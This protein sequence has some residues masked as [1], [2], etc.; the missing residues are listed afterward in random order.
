M[1]MACNCTP[2]APCEWCAQFTDVPRRE[3]GCHGVE[4][5][6]PTV[7]VLVERIER[8]EDRCDRLLAMLERVL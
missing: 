1:Q 6:P 4:T 2:H 5:T 3:C 8:L 7:D